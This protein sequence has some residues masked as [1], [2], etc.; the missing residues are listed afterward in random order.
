MMLEG[1]HILLLLVELKLYFKILNDHVAQVLLE[2]LCEFFY[3]KSINWNTKA[4]YPKNRD[5]GCHLQPPVNTV[6][7]DLEIFYFV[8][9]FLW[10]WTHAKHSFL[11]CVKVRHH[12]CPVILCSNQ[13]SFLNPP[14]F[15]YS[16]VNCYRK[17][18][19]LYKNELRLALYWNQNFACSFKF[20][21]MFQT[22]TLSSTA[23]CWRNQNLVVTRSDAWQPT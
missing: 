8:R 7:M 9:W 10:D 6:L 20:L 18:F 23:P 11:E 4:T 21:T 1:S 14:Q 22:S 12:S 5:K 17:L 15:I 19:K 16:G 2:L 13:M 3:Y